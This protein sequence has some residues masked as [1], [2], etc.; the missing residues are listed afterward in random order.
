LE[1]LLEYALDVKSRAIELL[2]KCKFNKAIRWSLSRRRELNQV[3][4]SLDATQIELK[5]A[6]RE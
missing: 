6:G 4:A 1:E 5:Q 3:L 2:S